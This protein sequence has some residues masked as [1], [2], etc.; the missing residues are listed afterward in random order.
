MSSTDDENELKKSIELDELKAR[1]SALQ[2][3]VTRFASVEQQ[4]INARDSLDYELVMYKRLSD[5][6]TKIIKAATL[7][8]LLNLTT[9]SI[10]DVTEMEFSVVC[11]K[12]RD[13]FQFVSEGLRSPLKE[14]IE[15]DI[16]FVLNTSLD[17]LNERITFSGAESVLKNKINNS[18]SD[19]FCFT[20]CFD[21][22]TV[23]VGVF[24]SQE[25]KHIFKFVPERLKTIFNVF[26]SQFQASFINY[27]KSKR[28]EDQIGQIKNSELELKKLSLIA[29]KTRNG[30]IISDKYGKVEWVNDSFT[31]ITGFSL[32][33]VIGRRPGDFLQK[34]KVQ[35]DAR[36]VLSE[37]LQKKEAVN[38]TILNY[39]KS[40]KPYYNQLEILPVFNEQGEHTN[41]IA[42][43]RDITS[44]TISQRE[45]MKVLSRFEK[46]SIHAE[47]GI[48]ERDYSE[49]KTIWNE[50]LL[51]QYGILEGLPSG[52]DYFSFWKSCIHPEDRDAVVKT[53]ERFIHS[54][55][56]EVLSLK[57][58]IIPYQSDQVKYIKGL[59]LLEFD[60]QG[61]LSR[62][63]GSS[64]DY[65][66]SRMSQLRLEISEKKYRDIIEYMRL[67]LAETDI[68]GKIIYSNSE[69]K[70]TDNASLLLLGNSPAARL[71][72]RKRNAEIINYFQTGERTF[73]VEIASQSSEEFKTR[74]YL[75]TS[76]SSTGEEV[77]KRGFINI[78]IDITP[79]KE[80]QRKLEA[81][82]NDRIAFLSQVANMKEF[83]EGVLDYAPARIA[84]FN[85]HSEVLYINNRLLKDEPEWLNSVGYTIDDLLVNDTSRS[86]SYKKM[87]ELISECVESAGLVQKEETISSDIVI[88]RSA[89]PHYNSNGNLEYIIVTGLDISDLKRIQHDLLLSNNQLRKINSELD[90]FVYSVSHDLRSPLTSLNGIVSQVLRVG[91]ID[92][93]SRRFLE[94]GESSI[95][96]LD[97]TIQEILEY[98]RNARLEVVSEE[99]NLNE[100]IQPIFDDLKFISDANMEFS[101]SYDQSPFIV[102]DKMRLSALLKNIVSNSVK[103]RN[104]NQINPYVRVHMKIQSNIA[105]ISVKDNGI[106]IHSDHLEKV[107]EMFYRASS[108]VSGTGLGLYICREIAHKLK[109]EIQL[110]SY[111]GV[112]TSVFIKLPQYI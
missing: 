68:Y 84:V 62:M 9:E 67:G 47:L 36:K 31:T 61:E 73:E 15:S 77:D 89:L 99:I 72:I 41:F 78:F 112:G 74:H 91:E 100:L 55:S 50:V 18:A 1:Y 71:E 14:Q 87:K 70:K 6:S 46:I 32:K 56:R 105:E 65:T 11:L 43:Q 29:T 51:K 25:R 83:Y 37:S 22:F 103:Y 38:V 12:E 45:L 66:D 19:F 26:V 96:R 79:Q 59:T 23:F 63:I 39:T 76:G 30:V 10:V 44:E 106:G 80:L 98:S 48:W 7:D 86:S 64:Q 54:K 13:D 3:R 33:E 111:P 95:T 92:D 8:E 4:L 27:I 94:M 52:F 102:S 85:N 35:S 104:P 108:S 2:L 97:G 90:N 57:F 93:K 60:E 49:N 109:G 101:F 53:T 16:S 58:R 82:L 5:F 107:F 88:L 17:S 69:F 28:I 21:E 40:G 42:L 34:E 20:F 24:V 110:E 75:V 81:A